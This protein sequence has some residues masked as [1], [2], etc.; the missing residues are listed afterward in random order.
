MVSAIGYLLQVADAMEVDVICIEPRFGM[1][2]PIAMNWRISWV[3][4]SSRKNGLLLCLSGRAIRLKPLPMNVPGGSSNKPRLPRTCSIGPLARNAI[5]MIISP[6][7]QIIA[8]IVDATASPSHWVDATN[9]AQ[10]GKL[11]NVGLNK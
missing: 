5:A 6:C 8:G 3:A 9:F 11:A 4:L 10:Y 7:R 2:P 1:S